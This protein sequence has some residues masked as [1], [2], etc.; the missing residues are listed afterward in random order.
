M[1]IM[2]L[3]K[4]IASPS[5]EKCH[6]LR[7]LLEGFF[8]WIDD[9]LKW[10]E[11]KR[12]EIIVCVQAYLVTRHTLCNLNAW[13]GTVLDLSDLYSTPSPS[14]SACTNYDSELSLYISTLNMIFFTFGSKWFTFGFTKPIIKLTKSNLMRIKTNQHIS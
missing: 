8:G 3:F 9:H 13:P 1:L 12:N 6:L 5:C 14:I 11:R 2:S 7:I 4:K 10:K